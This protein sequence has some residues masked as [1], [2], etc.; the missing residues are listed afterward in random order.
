MECSSYVYLPL[1]VLAT[2]PLYEVWLFLRSNLKS[3]QLSAL[4]KT[5]FLAT[6][7]GLGAGIAESV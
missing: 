7:L 1:L 3:A 4:Y 2:L 6:T 5:N